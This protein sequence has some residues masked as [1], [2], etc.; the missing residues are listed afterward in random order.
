MGAYD[1]A[2]VCEMV[3]LYLLKKIKDIIAQALVGFYRDDG[4][5]QI[6]IES[7]KSCTNV[8]KKKI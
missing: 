7:G 3:G 8:L 2:E 4:L 6:S 1:G 5:A